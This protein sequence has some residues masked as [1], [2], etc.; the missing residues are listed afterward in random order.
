MLKGSIDMM[1]N[2]NAGVVDA[3]REISCG[4]QELAAKLDE[5][6]SALE[7]IVDTGK[8]LQG[9]AGNLEQ[10]VKNTDIKYTVDD[11][12]VKIMEK[13]RGMLESLAVQ[14]EIAS[15]NPEAHGGMLSGKMTANPEI[16]AIWS[17]DS[18]GNFVF[19]KPPAGLP[20]AS[21]R[22]WW[23]RAVE[24]KVYLSTPYISAIT[25]KPCI[26]VSVP[27]TSGGSV[28][29]VLGADVGLEDD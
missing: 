28:I 17:N 25:R 13:I 2:I 20:N 7:E 3:Y 4:L 11:G 27:V 10:S 18:A 6:G 15:M 14:P 12:S 8:L 24:G 9:V 22:E 1:G 16:E 26:T 29:G 5:R 23:L 19:S 21:A